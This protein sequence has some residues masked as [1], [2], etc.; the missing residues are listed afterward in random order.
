MAR[1]SPS[2]PRR[3]TGLLAV[4]LVVA[5]ASC[6]TTGEQPDQGADATTTSQAPAGDVGST[7]EPSTAEDPTTETTQDTT[8]A[9]T[10]DTTDEPAAD[11]ADACS[12]LTRTDAEEA[13]GEPVVDDSDQYADE[14]WWT[15]EGAGLK[16]VNLRIAQPDLE[17][18]RAGHDNDDW[19]PIDLGDEAFVRVGPF[20]SVELRVGDAVYEVNVT[21]STS[22]DPD[23]VALELA[24]LVAARLT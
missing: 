10:D 21:Y 16:S 12:L 2:R 13:F 6:G 19:E 4:A 23:A 20:S 1:T 5:L 3:V 22:G 15:S 24:E 17:E 14:C 7:S 11:P 18:W 8:A 9:A